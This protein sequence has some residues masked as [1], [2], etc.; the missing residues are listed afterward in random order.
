MATTLARSVGAP[1]ERVDAREKVTGAARYAFEQPIENVAY[2][3]LVQAT[4]ARGAV[5]AVDPS[6]ALAEPGVLAVLDH[7]NAPRT[8]P[9]QDG[10]LSVLQSP[11]VH[12]RGQI[13]AAVVADSLEAAREGAARVVVSYDEEP[14]DVVLRE[15]HPRLYTPEVVNPS[16]PA[17]TEQG[18][19]EKGLREAD[20]VHEATYSTPAQHNNPMEP[21]AT[22]AAWEGGALTLWDS[23]Q[24]APAARGTLAQVFGLEPEQ[25]RVISQHVGGGF[26]SKGTPRPHAVVAALAA[27]QL[28]RPVKV[29][30]TRQQMFAFVGYR[31]PTIQ[32]VRLGAAADGA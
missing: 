22:L 18:D 5:A 16:F 4:I 32:R 9:V 24:G 7:A 17:T 6:A 21:H 11:A 25:C 14:H 26:G 15:D 28:Q 8:T 31:T 3:W 30:V 2:G 27:K 12:Y 20:R 10:E 13:V 29:A 23:T 1:A 19:V